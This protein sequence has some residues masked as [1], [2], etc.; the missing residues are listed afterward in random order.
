MGSILPT[1]LDWTLILLRVRDE[2]CVPF[3]GAGA[4]L[5]GPGEMG[6]PTASELAGELAQDC[7]YPG[8][9]TSD[10]LRVAQY[11]RMV[12]DQHELRKFI[13]DRLRGHGLRPQHLSP[14]MYELHRAA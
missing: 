13:R 8:T 1:D 14:A 7:E 10:L 6:L 9:D 11:Y 3:L 4:S 5:G 12:Y 2:R